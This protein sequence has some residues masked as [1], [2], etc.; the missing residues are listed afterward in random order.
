[1]TIVAQQKVSDNDTNNFPKRDPT[2]IS[3]ALQK[4]S[5]KSHYQLHA[6]V[7]LSKPNSQMISS[8]LA[9]SK[10]GSFLTD[11]V[12]GDGND[13]DDDDDGGIDEREEEEECAK[14]NC[15]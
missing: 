7:S 14:W 12:N 1:M 3:L 11:L 2:Q 13:D 9:S 4:K 6:G 10:R 15:N 5:H 8:L